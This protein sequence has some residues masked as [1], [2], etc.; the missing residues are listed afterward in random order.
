MGRP[1]IEVE[2]ICRHFGS[3]GRRAVALDQ[4][5]FTVGAGE[6]VALLGVNGAGKTTLA[7]I[8]AGILLPTSGTARIFGRDVVTDAK[9]ARK[10]MSVIFGGD[11]GL[12]PM[13]S[14]EDN[15]AYFGMLAGVPRKVLRSR[16]LAMLKQVGLDAA[17]HRRVE[18]YSKGMKQRLHIAIGLV[19]QP[20]VLILDEPTVGLDPNEAQRL[21]DAIAE[22]R[23]SQVAV[24]LTSHYLLDVER[25][26]DRVVMIKNGRVAHDLRL[27]EF[28][29]LVGHVATVAVTVRGPIRNMVTLKPVAVTERDNSSTA[30]FH[31]E[32]WSP[33]VLQALSS[34]FSSHDILDMTVTESTLEEAFA[35]ATA[36]ETTN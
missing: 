30:I 29:A 3:E 5:S 15:L 18:T 36:E 35:L 34:E 27:R 31:I 1:A 24:L 26:A 22:L 32:H 2:S 4:M 12:Y 23:E 13:L 8:L 16:S 9:E 25:L 11:R 20:K 7:K 10:Q 19:S 14:G 17:R 33:Q 21:R 6:V 28:V